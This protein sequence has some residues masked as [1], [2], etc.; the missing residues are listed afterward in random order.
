MS[1]HFWAFEEG[2]GGISTLRLDGP[3]AEESWWGDE[4]TPAQFRAE[5]AAHPG[6][7]MVYIN[8]PGGDVCAASQMYAALRE[9]NGKITVR[10][11][12]LA[13]SAASVVAMAGDVVEMAPTAYMMIHNAWTVAQGNAE[14]MEQAAAMLA[15]VDKGIRGVY[16]AKT[17]KTDRELCRMMEAETWMSAPTALAEGFI[18]AIAYTQPDAG[19]GAD[20]QGGAAAFSDA[21]AAHTHS[22]PS[23]AHIA[24]TAPPAFSARRMRETCAAAAMA[25]SQK[26]PPVPLKRTAAEAAAQQHNTEADAALRARLRLLSM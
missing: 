18:D 22:M 26:T 23:L 19:K 3:I 5:L 7:L 10:I 17:K 11:D 20:A 2:G 1:K 9:H 12:G 4:V 16:A 14:D 6:D 8:S 25:H 21:A 13:A 15:E 24:M